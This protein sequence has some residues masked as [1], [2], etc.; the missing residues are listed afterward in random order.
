MF[1]AALAGGC[2]PRIGA[3][4]PE[5]TVVASN[6]EAPAGTTLV[7][8]CTPTGPELCFN[9]IDDNCNGV[10]DEGCGVPTGLL[11]FTLAWAGSA[12]VDLVLVTPSKERVPE[13]RARSTPSGFHLDRDCPQD[14]CGGQNVENIHYDGSEPPR[15]HYVVEITLGELH[16]SAPPIA[17]RFGARLGTQTVGFDVTLSPGDDARKQFGFDL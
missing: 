4:A 10:I 8:A 2:A 11:Q 12:E 1:V 5:P 14:G 6:V 3:K 9:A 17:A 15:G 13:G 16:D 7:Q